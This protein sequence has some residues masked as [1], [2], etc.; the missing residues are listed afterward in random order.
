[1]EKKF[2]GYPLPM[3]LS[4]VDIEIKTRILLMF[5]TKHNTFYHVDYTVILYIVTN[6]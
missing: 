6:I 1:M 3:N 5:K 2:Q 4:R